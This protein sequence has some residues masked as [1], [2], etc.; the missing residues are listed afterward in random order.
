MLLDTQGSECS[1]CSHKEPSCL[2]ALASCEH[3][4][5]QIA[6]PRRDDGISTDAFRNRQRL[7]IETLGLHEVP[8]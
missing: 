5:A 3:D 7:A 2:F 1:R 6:E 4:L 8:A